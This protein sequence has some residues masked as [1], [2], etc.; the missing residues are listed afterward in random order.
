MASR[1]RGRPR[2]KDTRLAAALDAMR[3]YG[4]PQDLVEV[5][6]GELLNVYGGNEGWIFI[7]DSSYSV[8]VETLLEKTNAPQDQQDDSPQH[9]PGDAD[10]RESSAVGS[11]IPTCPNSGAN[12]MLLTNQALDS[13]SQPNEAPDSA[14]ESHGMRYLPPAASSGGAEAP[15]DR[16]AQSPP[17]N[18]D[19]M[20]Y[21]PPPQAASSGGAETFGNSLAQSP[22]HIAD[23]L[24]YLPP[25]PPASSGGAETLGNSLG[26]SPPR[27]E[28]G[29]RYLPRPLAAS[30]GGA[31]TLGNSLA[32]SPPH[33]ADGM[34]YLPRPQAARTGGAENLGNSL[35]QSPSRIADGMRYLPWPPAASSGRAETLGNSLAQSPPHIADGMHYLPRPLEANSGGA[36]TLGKNLAQPPPY[37]AGSM[38][39]FP[40]PLAASS[41]MRYLPP[42][43]VNQFPLPDIRP[44]RR[45][46]P[47]HGWISNDDEIDL[48][49]LTPAPL[50]EGIAKLLKQLDK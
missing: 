3:P 44:T 38:R 1:P 36:E 39:Y 42:P 25:P 37:I 17:P 45:R 14:H 9:D 23:G 48:V 50:P 10:N 49:Q 7:E 26:Q 4:F 5:T 46:R 29:M 33:I 22:P 24:I 27:I 16:L 19:G 31:E 43:H 2:K 34:R 32:Q 20:R 8:L 11:S 21:L 12:A 47:Y 35:G 40:P 30:S 18:A 28:D 41:G 6:V 13:A 15:G